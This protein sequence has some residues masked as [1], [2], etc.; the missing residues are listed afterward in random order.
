M[1]FPQSRRNRSLI[2]WR[3]WITFPDFSDARVKAKI[4]TGA[5][6]SAI[7]AANIALTEKDGTA[8]VQFTI[9]PNQR[10]PGHAVTC[11]APLINRRSITNSGG[12]KESRFVVRTVV[13]LGPHTWPIEVSLTSRA[14]MGF[15]MLLGRNAL[16]GRFLVAPDRSFLEG[17]NFETVKPAPDVSTR[18]KSVLRRK[19]TAGESE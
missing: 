14:S 6:T 3:E 9:Y 7:H 4:D 12:K 13:G 1:R 16:R 10:D 15:R 5:R 8:F 2:G 18:T 11:L 17:R 19:H